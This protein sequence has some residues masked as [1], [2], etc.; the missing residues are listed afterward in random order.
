[1]KVKTKVPMVFPKKYPIP[2]QG[3]EVAKYMARDGNENMK[4]TM[5]TTT[6]PISATGIGAIFLISKM[7]SLIEANFNLTPPI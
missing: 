1:M 3:L 2:P 7:F 6:A 5:V 4:L